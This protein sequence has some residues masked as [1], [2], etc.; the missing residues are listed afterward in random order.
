MRLIWKI[1]EWT[2]VLM[3]LPLVPF[4]WACRLLADA[5]DDCAKKSRG[6]RRR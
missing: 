5:A 6:V 2:L 1:L 3:A 4:H